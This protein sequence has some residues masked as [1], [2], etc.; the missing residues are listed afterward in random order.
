MGR[1]A[2]YHAALQAATEAT[3]ARIQ[4]DRANAPNP[5]KKVFTVLVKRFLQPSLNATEAWKAA[6]IK[7]TGV[8]VTFKQATGS[9]LV[10]YIAAA[11]IEVAV[12]LMT[13]TELGL[14]T[15]SQ[16][17]GYT[18]HPTFTDNFRRVMG[19]RPSEVE[20]QPMPMA[21]IGD[22][23]S[24]RA[25]RGLLEPDE[26]VTYIEHLMR[27]CPE[28]TVLI[29]K[30]LCN[31]NLQPRIVVD[32]ER[33]DEL[34]ALGV[35]E[36]ISTLPFE[37]QCQQV[38][39]YQFRSTVLFDLLR[40]RSRWEGHTDHQR[41]VQLAKLALV[42]LE[43]CDNVFGS[44]IHD[45]RALGW[46]WLGNAQRLA[47]D[48]ANASTSFEH[49]D[50]EWEKPRENK[51]TSVLAN[52][53]YLKGALQ[54]VLRDY[55]QAIRHLNQ[56][57]ALFQTLNQL[58]DEARTLIFRAATYGYAGSYRKAVQDLTE[59]LALIDENTD[60]EFAFAVRGNLA[61][62]LIRAGMAESASKELLQARHLI[63][64]LDD[65]MGAIRVDWIA[66][67]LAEIQGDLENAKRWY[68]KVRIALRGAGDPRYL[69][70]ISVDLMLIHRQQ[71]DLESA[72][73]LAAETLP[74]LGSMDLH[75]ETIAAVGLLA[76]AV[77]ERQLSDQVLSNLRVALRHDPLTM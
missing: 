73:M 56:S 35:W 32:G 29:R 26:M 30:K 24:L 49:A 23:I 33:T 43:D 69:G 40:K 64:Q 76:N 59:A 3:R 63:G 67:D 62:A 46:A 57:C 20:R 18:Y 53:H 75:T 58:K 72:A 54:M 2:P 28:A 39:R 60:K 61:N 19:K 34:Q 17:V 13:T 42:S 41:G 50:R 22:E 44:R 11:R 55:K 66:G 25:G 65:P 70:M 5:L 16:L 71:G 27:I 51:D 10:Q 6:G 9:T 37:E 21:L 74:I 31:D 4:R 48:L 7:D 1:D 36:Q 15:I 77:K 12:V 38:R 45:L 47:V 14:S 8:M 52:L 68:Q